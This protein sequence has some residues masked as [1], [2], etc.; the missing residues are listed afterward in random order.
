MARLNN[1]QYE[2]VGANLWEVRI[3]KV[4]GSY[5]V[6]RGGKWA[7]EYKVE[8]W[9]KRNAALYRSAKG[10]ARVGAG[11]KSN[12]SE[13]QQITDIFNGVLA[14]VS[15]ASGVA[16]AEHMEL[17]ADEL[18]KKIFENKGKYN[19][20]SGNLD[21]AY[22]ATIVQGRR[23]VKIIKLDATA[24]NRFEASPRSSRKRVKRKIRNHGRYGTSYRYKKYYERE[25][26]YDNTGIGAGVDRLG[27]FGRSAGDSTQQSGIIIENTAP[28]AGAVQ[29]KGYTV[30]PMGIERSYNGKAA[31][32]QKQLMMQLTKK[33]LKSAKLI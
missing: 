10:G 19:I 20:Y 28:Y 8:Q 7:L 12:K 25:N 15:G 23:I 27:G 17:A 5:E 4:D 30:I 6:F 18:L 11:R 26:G 2:Q 9:L 1:I 3:P 32:K 29:A 13:A 21:N 33:F 22:Q 16:Q 24:G 14:A 31:A